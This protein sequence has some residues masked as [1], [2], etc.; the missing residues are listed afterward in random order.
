ME[1]Q[2]SPGVSKATHIRQCYHIRVRHYS[3]HICALERLKDPPL[4]SHCLN[5]SS[6]GLVIHDDPNCIKVGLF[7]M[8]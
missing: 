3:T 7:M 4:S 5:G 1:Y 2:F 8:Y 6:F